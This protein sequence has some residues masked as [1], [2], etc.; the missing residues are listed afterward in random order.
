LELDKE[1]FRMRIP[2]D[3]SV[4]YGLTGT[5]ILIFPIGKK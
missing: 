2:D 3:C 4:I 1:I 5:E